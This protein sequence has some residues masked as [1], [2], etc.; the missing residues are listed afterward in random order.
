MK[1]KKCV[2]APHTG[3]HGAEE[4]LKEEKPFQINKKSESLLE[5][6]NINLQELYSSWGSV[7]LVCGPGKLTQFYINLNGLGDK[8]W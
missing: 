6:K 2:L 4:P 1:S 7:R 8:N 5:W 3:Q